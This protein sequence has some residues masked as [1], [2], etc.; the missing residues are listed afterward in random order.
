MRA[1]IQRV[2][3]A[4]V[5]IQDRNNECSGEISQGFLIFLGVAQND[6]VVEADLLVKKIVGLRIFDDEEGKMN[7]DLS[8][9]NGSVLVVSQFT[10]YADCHHGRRP[11]FI[12]AG[13]VEKAKEL[14]EYFMD[15]I[16]QSG[17]KVE[18]GVFQTMM[19]VELTNDGPVTIWLDTND[20]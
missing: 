6:T 12:N 3:S 4:R 20:L 17:I 2:S 8:H 15:K 1:L 7:K 11:S 9:V 18:Q 5:L 10:L 14:Y 16:R 19:S 13:P